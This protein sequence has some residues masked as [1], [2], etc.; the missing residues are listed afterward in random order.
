MSMFGT[1]Q[2]GPAPPP[3]PAMPTPLPESSASQAAAAASGQGKVTVTPE[4]AARHDPG[5]V[6]DQ[7][8]PGDPT[9]TMKAGVDPMKLRANN[10]KVE[11][12][13]ELR[14]RGKK[15]MNYGQGE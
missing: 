7:A 12:L 14:D 10:D 3:P 15:R 6:F 8:T 13:E 1:P 4:M 11:E 5:D 2:N 9:A